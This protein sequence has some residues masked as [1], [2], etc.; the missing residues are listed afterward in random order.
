MDGESERRFINSCLPPLHTMVKVSLE[1]PHRES[2]LTPSLYRL[3]R[4]GLAGAQRAAEAAS[5]PTRPPNLPPSLSTPRRAQQPDQHS[6]LHP[7]DSPR[8]SLPSLPPP[9]SPFSLPPQFASPTSSSSSS[10]TSPVLLSLP[11]LPVCTPRCTPGRAGLNSRSSTLGGMPP[12]SK[13]S[14]IPSSF[15]RTGR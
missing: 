5:P 3:S 4:R 6:Q 2:V 8:P 12:Q 13:G 10:S 15:G 14:A 9:R 7:L 11:H 1:H